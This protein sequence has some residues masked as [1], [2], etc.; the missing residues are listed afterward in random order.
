MALWNRDPEGLRGSIAN[1]EATPIGRQ[2]VP[3]AQTATL[4]AGLAAMEGRTTEALALYREALRAW[5]AIDQD[6]DL[7]M[8][9]IDMAT[10]L[11]PSI[12]DVRAASDRARTIFTRVGAKPYLA[13]LDAL[14][15]RRP[16]APVQ[17]R[18]A[19]SPP[20]PAEDLAV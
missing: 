2:A 20:V 13:K 7:A 11:D 5:E 4:V 1:I 12:P 17:D 19:E 9:G 14:L 3:R 15:A 8:C 6:W 18:T 10:V 16:A